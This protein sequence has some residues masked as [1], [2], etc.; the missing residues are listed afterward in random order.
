MDEQFPSEAIARS[1][2]V[3]AD[4]TINYYFI[5]WVRDD[6]FIAPHPDYGKMRDGRAFVEFL[7]EQEAP[8]EYYEVE[9]PHDFTAWRGHFEEC[10]KFLL[11][12][13]P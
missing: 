3:H 10:I 2:A 7:R 4:T 13:K 6:N 5:P 11:A 1:L 8:M 12:G 9:G